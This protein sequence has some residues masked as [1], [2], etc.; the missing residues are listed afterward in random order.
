LPSSLTSLIRASEA[1]PSRKIGKVQIYKYGKY[2]QGI[3]DDDT[4]KSLEAEYNRK[5]LHST[6]K[7]Y[8][9]DS[10]ALNAYKAPYTPKKYEEYEYKGERYI[11]VVANPADDDSVLANGKKVKSGD[12]GWFKVEP[13]E[14]MVE[15]SGKWKGWWV[16][17]LG[18]AAGIKFDEKEKYDGKN[19]DKTVMG[20]W[21]E[22]DF[23]KEMQNRLT[24]ARTVDALANKKLNYGVTVDDES[25]SISKQIEFYIKTGKSFMLH[26]PSGVGKTARVEAIDPDL[27]AVP[28][29]NGVLPEDIVG[30]VRYPNGQTGLP[31]EM[32]SE[33][34]SLEKELEKVDKNSTAAG[35]E[36][37]RIRKII[38]SQ[39]AATQDG[40]WVAPDWY[41]ELVRKCQSEPNQQHVLFIDEVTNAKPTTQSLIFHIVL[42]KSISPSKG[43]L[44]P[45]AVVVL[46]GNDKR[47]SG[48]AY[49]MPEPLFRRMSGNIYLDANLPEWL[50]WA[51]ERSRKHP[52]DP[53]RLNVHPLVSRFLA[54]HQEAFYSEYDEENPQQ[55]AV[56]PRGWEQVSDIIYDNGNVIQRQLIENKIGRENAS[57]LLGFALT[58]MI[59]LEDV[60]AGNIDKDNVPE[61]SDSKLAATLA[62]RQVDKRDVERVREF[63]AK[64]LGVE[65]LAIFDSVWVEN[66]QEHAIW[67][68]N[69]TNKT[70]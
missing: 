20:K 11:R 46:A 8:T 61:T 68:D 64:Y 26:G 15:T 9:F 16:S 22:N 35:Q 66:N 69:I 19:F 32:I 45:N 25:K 42:K 14:W 4:L 30:K 27:T 5:N 29:W 49:N 48:A 56:D 17:H 21:L 60:L 37:A 57:A 54:A 1:S 59:T 67:L 44:P 51:S 58:P 52:N 36:L 3:A 2:P 13:I 50:E 33:L 31:L 40:V 24:A 39:P 43:K 28:L 62:M 63:I 18:L 65:N 34:L 7:S 6:G 10:Q 53:N 55:W 70:R 38:E 41:A 47:E 12:I 23:Y